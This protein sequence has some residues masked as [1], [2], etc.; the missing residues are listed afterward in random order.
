MIRKT[1][2]RVTLTT[3]REPAPEPYASRIREARDAVSL[4]SGIIGSDPREHFV[5]VYLDARHKVLA[6]HVVSIGTVSDTKVHPRE[7]FGPGL[8][9]AASAILVAHNHPS[10]DATASGDDKRV[11]DRLRQ[12]GELL[13]IEL[14]DHVVIGCDKYYS[15]AADE[16]CAMI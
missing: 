3:V 10:G 6:V 9:L 16:Y 2:Q 15:F 14:L 7:V 1:F 13:G 5:A 11:T 12:A 8:M 4:V